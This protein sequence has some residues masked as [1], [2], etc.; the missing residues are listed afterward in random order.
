MM[1]KP[2]LLAGILFALLL[3]MLCASASA[4]PLTTEEILEIKAN[5]GS[6]TEAQA[7]EYLESRDSNE[8]T[9]D[10]HLGPDYT[11]DGRKILI[12]RIPLKVAGSD[13]Y[14][15][16]ENTFYA[17]ADDVI[18]IHDP[19]GTHINGRPDAGTSV[20]L[21]SGIHVDTGGNELKEGTR[22]LL[23]EKDGRA[24][25]F[26]AGAGT[27]S[28]T[29]VI[30]KRLYIMRCFQDLEFHTP[31][32]GVDIDISFATIAFPDGSGYIT[33]GD[34]GNLHIEIDV[35]DDWEIYWFVPVYY[36]YLDECS[37]GISLPNLTVHME[38]YSGWYSVEV[39]LC[40]IVE[41][42]EYG[43]AIDMSP[44]FSLEGTGH[45]DTV[46]SMSAKEGFHLTVVDMVAVTDIGWD[47]TNPTFDLVDTDMEGELYYGFSWG[48]ALTWAEV[49]GF[50]GFYKTGVVLKAAKANNPFDPNDPSDADWHVC[51]T[52]HCL[53]GN[54][55]TRQGP[56]SANIVLINGMI[57]I[58]IISSKPWDDKPFAEYYVS[59][60]FG[61]KSMSSLCPHWAYRL[62]VNVVDQDGNA[63]PTANV[64]YNDVPEH[65]EDYAS[66][67]TD[68]SGHAVLCTATGKIDVTAQLANPEDPSKPF[69][70]TQ[71]ID[72]KAQ[73]ESITLTLNLP[74][75][76]V[77]FKNSATGEATDW[78]ADIPFIPVVSKDVTLPNKIPGLSGRIFT[79]WNTKKDGSGTSY[80]PG[81]KLTLDDDLTLW[82]QW[83]IAEDQW[84]VIYNANGGTKAPGPQEIRKGQ[85]A[86]LTR[87]LPESGRMIFKGWTPDPRKMDPVYQPG[88]KLKYDS[89]KNYVVLYAIWNLSP[90]PK[91]IHVAFDPNGV[92]DAVLPADVW[93]E[94]GS[95]LQL[96]QARAD[97]GSG[98][99]FVG[100]SENPKAKT[101]DFLA[102]HTYYFYR[103]VVLYAIWE[104]QETITLTFRDSILGPVS[105][106][107]DPIS[108]VPSMSRNVKIPDT[109]PTRSRM[110]FIG[111]NTA[112]DG[113]GI[114][115][116]PGSVITLR[117]DTTLWAQWKKLPPTGDAGHPVLWLSMVL[118]GF[119]GFML[120]KLLRKAGKRNE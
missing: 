36:L 10:L 94:Q 71:T 69:T 30:G 27:D 32:G 8:N 83:K 96:E 64:F 88:D 17:I 112:R 107:P 25:A 47:H 53:E 87:E 84:Y 66:A 54:I 39:P 73:A 38:R 82:A 81:T 19:D 21:G 118:L 15:P 43:F 70:V 89:Q 68:S 26:Y 37:L 74:T 113:S 29:L 77:Y 102:G 85:D 115:Y 3:L 23:L 20:P 2:V 59:S 44:T 72:K 60:T 55:H 18:L 57:S 104:K 120:P 35:H 76:H 93:F 97:L 33:A 92:K 79:G 91:P 22:V 45:G 14:V 100:W 67:T 110:L 108:I 49:A 119:A 4:K 13:V 116:A 103:D 42:L 61:D 86:V 6:I 106:I 90:V 99:A 5:G 98:W 117:E 80:A 78:P 41:P 51:G 56:F 50:G 40:E 109:R 11:L 12:S 1:K 34:K 24:H 95:W 114:N 65:Y 58:P 28:S 101:P 62:D 46:L 105:G 9:S 31:N 111:W 48:P 16:M 63:I 7:K 75:K 52:D